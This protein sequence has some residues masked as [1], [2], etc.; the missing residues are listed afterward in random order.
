MNYYPKHLPT[1]PRDGVLPISDKRMQSTA[2]IFHFRKFLIYLLLITLYL[3]IDVS[4]PNVNI[5]IHDPV[6]LVMGLLFVSTILVGQRYHIR[7]FD[8]VI[9][10]PVIGFILYAVFQVSFVAGKLL[11]LI[12]VVQLL[13]IVVLVFVLSDSKV[14]TLSDR[15][16][17]NILRI[18]F[19]F[20]SNRSDQYGYLCSYYRTEV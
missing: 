8:K 14:L 2:H 15:D 6:L 10:L 18:F 9:L 4:F 13:E 11:V 19:L 1:G 7:V 17:Y 16:I 3:P 5:N 12:T 20:F